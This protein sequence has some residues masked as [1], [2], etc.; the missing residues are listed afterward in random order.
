MTIGRGEIKLN[1]TQVRAAMK[2]AKI[3][4][5]S[6]ASFDIKGITGEMALG[7][8]HKTKN[9]LT[10]TSVFRV[11]SLSKPVFSYLVLKLINDNQSGKALPKLGEFNLPV[12][13]KFDLETPL[14]KIC[15]WFLDKFSQDPETQAKAMALT[16]RHV[17]SHTTGLPIKQQK[18]ELLKFQF[19][20]GTEYGYSNPGIVLLQK[21]IDTITGSNLQALAKA[22]VFALLGMT[23]TNFLSPEYLDPT[24]VDEV[25]L[26][27]MDAA[28]SVHT[29]ANDYALFIANWLTEMAL[30]GNE[31]LSQ[32]FESQISM[33]ADRWASNQ[34]LL[35]EDRKKIAWSLGFGL[36]VEVQIGGGVKATR[37]FHSGDMDNWRAFLAIDL[38]TKKG[39]V[40]LSNSPNGLLLTD[41]IVTPNVEL[42]DGLKYI[43]EK[44]GFARKLEPGWKEKEI[45]RVCKIIVK[46]EMDLSNLQEKGLLKIDD[47][48]GLCMLDIKCEKDHS[49]FNRVIKKEF[50]KFKEETQLEENRHY[51][52][53]AEADKEGNILHLKVNIFDKKLYNKFIDNLNADKLLPAS[54]SALQTS[55][56]SSSYKTPTLTRY[57]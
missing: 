14:H 32:A 45:D 15:P 25:R 21:T 4:G 30:E 12:G 35:E 16:A 18:G 44:Y 7:V 10:T 8:D 24:V 46:N 56:E 19:E 57:R 13:E 29:T 48:K 6:I 33:E 37:A 54:T 3:D 26:E 51:K 43:F 36:Q 49:I 52:I 27:R 20:P 2:D 9:D 17:L 23:N 55:L 42:N 1:E 47:N 31:L 39:I 22:N 34:G 28:N 38:E 5:V 50:D 40:F 53:E 41:C 11:A